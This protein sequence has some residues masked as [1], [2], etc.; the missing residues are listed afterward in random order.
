MNL[1]WAFFSF[2]RLIKLKNWF[3]EFGL[4][5]W[6][7]SSTFQH[8]YV[9]FHEPFFGARTKYRFEFFFLLFFLCSPKNC[10]NLSRIFLNEEI[11]TELFL[12]I[13][14]GTC[15]CIKIMM[16]THSDDLIVYLFCL[17]FGEWGEVR[18]LLIFMIKTIGWAIVEDIFLWFW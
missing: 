10:R 12:W 16:A 18:H 17:F 4:L 7:Q 13:S 11:K 14:Q 6:V 3:R 8:S 15:I 2:R 1:S 9:V 5:F